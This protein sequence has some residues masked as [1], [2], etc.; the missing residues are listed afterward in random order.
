M[1]EKNVCGLWNRVLLDSIDW[2]DPELTQKAL[3]GVPDLR[4]QGWG[5]LVTNLGLE[6]AL[7]REAQGKRFE[8][9]P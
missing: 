1:F 7:V 6:G 2:W 9:R 3:G 8:R 4:I 5:H